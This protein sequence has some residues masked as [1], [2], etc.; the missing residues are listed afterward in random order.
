MP[1]LSAVQTRLPN[2]ENMG[3]YS[4]HRERCASENASSRVGKRQLAKPP[5]FNA[6]RS[7]AR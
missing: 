7:S 3:L 1:N 4:S 6:E 2:P 5:N